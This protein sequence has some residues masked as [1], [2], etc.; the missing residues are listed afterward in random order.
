MG[1]DSALIIKSYFMIGIICET[2][3]KNYHMKKHFVISA[4]AAFLLSTAACTTEHVVAVRPDA[5]VIVERP[6]SPPGEHVY[7]DYEYKWRGGK[8]VAVP[9]YYVKKKS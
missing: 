4:V 3:I 8:Y 1:N 9:G 6:A 7:V 5:P 2:V